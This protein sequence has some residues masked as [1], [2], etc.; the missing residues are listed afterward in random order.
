MLTVK[1]YTD[2]WCGPCKQ[3]APVFDQLKQ[4][5]TNDLELKFM[6]IRMTIMR[7]RD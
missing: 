2:T 1:R 5:I 7:F 6:E 4:E 3:L